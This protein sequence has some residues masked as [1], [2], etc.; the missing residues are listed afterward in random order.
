MIIQ[1]PSVQSK[2]S[3]AGDGL[4]VCCHIQYLLPCKIRNSW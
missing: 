1:H 4:C 3:T 2:A